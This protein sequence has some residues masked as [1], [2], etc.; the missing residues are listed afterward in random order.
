MGLTLFIARGTN[1]TNGGIS[2]TFDTVCAINIPGPSEPSADC[3]AVRLEQHMKGC[4][5]IVPVDRPENAIGPMFG[6]NY[7]ASPD[8]APGAA[9]KT[10]SAM[11][12]GRAA[13]AGPGMR[14]V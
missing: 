9:T 3:P 6:G 7:A 14:R 5:R 8:R 1:C 2:S 13:L 12:S 4:L 11:S 10:G